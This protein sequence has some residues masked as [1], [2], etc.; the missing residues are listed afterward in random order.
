MALGRFSN[1]LKIIAISIQYTKRNQTERTDG[2][3]EHAYTL[4]ND[5]WQPKTGSQ[6]ITELN[7]VKQEN[8]YV[9]VTSV[10]ITYVHRRRS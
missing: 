9:N 1:A 6:D 4:S 10:R 3:H 7:S 5:A 8:G 2:Q